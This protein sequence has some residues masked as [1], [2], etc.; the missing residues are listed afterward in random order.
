[1]NAIKKLIKGTTLK[2]WIVLSMFGCN[3]SLI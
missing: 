3:R 2:E 1:M